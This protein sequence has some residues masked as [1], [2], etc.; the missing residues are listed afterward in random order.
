MNW[1]FLSNIFVSSSKKY[2]IKLPSSLGY[3][4][5]NKSELTFDYSVL[6]NDNL[7]F[8]YDSSH[9]LKI[10]VKSLFLSQCNIL[11]LKLRVL[12]NQSIIY[13]FLKKTIYGFWR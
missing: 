7:F 5:L 6:F 3:I 9:K 4:P 11:T 8:G 13:K 12:L 10:N 2:S 1:Q